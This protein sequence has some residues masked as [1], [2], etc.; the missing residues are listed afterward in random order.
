MQF[1]L[2]TKKYTWTRHAH[3]K[4]KFYGLS[5]QRIRRVIKNPARAEVGIAPNTAAVM[6]PITKQGK[7]TQ[8][9]WAMYQDRGNERIVITAWRYPGTSPIRGQ[10]PIPNDIRDELSEILLKG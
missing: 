7:T 2:Q 10:I 8:E 6:Q 9:I 1:Q 4:L 3:E 5:E